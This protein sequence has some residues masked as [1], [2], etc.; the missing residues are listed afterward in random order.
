MVLTLEDKNDKQD[1]PDES[2]TVRK[3]RSRK[4]P[5]LVARSRRRT[6]DRR[7]SSGLEPGSVETELL[8]RVRSA[9]LGRLIP[10]LAHDINQPTG[11]A[12]MTAEASLLDVEDGSPNLGM[13]RRSLTTIRD[14]ME[15]IGDLA[16]FI[17]TL[18]M[19]SGGNEHL[20]DAGHVVQTA[21][22][23][24]SPI[25]Q[26]SNVD[27][28]L[29]LP[30]GRALVRGNATQFQMAV[31][32]V[33]LTIWDYISAARKPEG[34]EVA[35]VGILVHGECLQGTFNLDVV[36]DMGGDVP[37]TAGGRA[38]LASGEA[39]AAA[40]L[41]AKRMGGKFRMRSQGT[42]LHARLSLP[43]SG[44]VTDTVPLP[45]DTSLPTS[46]T[47]PRTKHLNILLVDDESLALE[48]ILAHLSRQG[49]AVVTAGNGKEALNHFMAEK[50]DVV[51]TDLRMP[52][53]S[54]NVLI[55]KVRA[56]D[57]DVPIIVMTGHAMPADEEQAAKDGAFAVMRKPIRLRDLTAL[58][59]GLPVPFASETG[60]R[61]RV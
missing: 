31:L 37:G 15:R 42:S 2:V 11:I 58:I 54:G 47:V 5:S 52:V 18:G 39:I 41:I 24:L 32:T 28:D 38:A 6:T 10:H 29:S 51:V 19:D 30:D 17:G 44:S 43:V 35:N 53:M 33:Y 49:H 40:R 14:Q 27:I 56:L 46:D 61:K 25:F 21:A 26:V 9:I 50:P 34:N 60:R 48:G 7:K 55:R 1:Q 12:R 13:L 3:K 23:R 45:V 8:N 16:A 22:R 59:N 4:R 20:F 57:T 36:C